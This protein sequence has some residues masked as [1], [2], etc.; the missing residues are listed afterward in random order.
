MDVQIPE[1]LNLAEFFLDHNL[2]QGRG[3]KV[4]IRF[5]GR[6]LTY[7][8]L[9]RDSHRLAHALVGLGLEPEQRVLLM[10]P[11]VPEF[12]VAWFAVQRAG[13]VCAAVSPDVTAEEAGYYLGYTRAK[14]VIASQAAAK[15][16]EE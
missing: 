14:I 16:L 8:E 4:A 11:D 9:A 12:A 15:T 3:E 1:R 7:A 5:E 6:E 13:G 10:L 2:E